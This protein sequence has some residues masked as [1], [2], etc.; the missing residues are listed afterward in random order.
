MSRLFGPSTWQI[1]ADELAAQVDAARSRKDR[2]IDALLS[3]LAAP[4]PALAPASK[5]NGSGAYPPIPKTA[6]AFRAVARAKNK[7]KPPV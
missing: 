7:K 5:L 6:P 2:A 1:A 3:A 4:A